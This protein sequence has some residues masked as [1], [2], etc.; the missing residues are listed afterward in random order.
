MPVPGGVAGWTCVG[1]RAT[2]RQTY[3]KRIPA[4]LT[5]LAQRASSTA[6]C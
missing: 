1:E 4:S 6:I 2:I 3:S 5:S